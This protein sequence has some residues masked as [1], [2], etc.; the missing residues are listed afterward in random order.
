MLQKVKEKLNGQFLY[1]AIDETTDSD[2][3]PRC[4]VLAGSLSSIDDTLSRLYMIDFV[5]LVTTNNVTVQ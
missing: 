3:R 1:I 5:N 4:V 2:R